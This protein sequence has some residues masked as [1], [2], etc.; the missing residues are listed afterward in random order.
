MTLRFL[1]PT[2]EVPANR[3]VREANKATS[4]KKFQ[5]VASLAEKFLS[6]YPDGFEDQQYYKDERGYK[7]E[8]AQV[9]KEKLGEETFRS[10]LAEGRFA[11]IARIALSLISKTNLV[12]PNESMALADA[13]KKQTTYHERFAQALFTLLYAPGKQGGHFDDF[14]GL[15]EEMK[16]CKWTTATYFPFLL[17]PEEEIF[18]KPKV[19]QEAA[20]AFTY[21]G[22]NYEPTPSWAGY[23]RMR[24]F[25]RYVKEELERQTTLVPRDL[26]DVQGFYWCVQQ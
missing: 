7:E 25:A 13:L 8:A 5:S 17:R 10:L 21:R 6:Q 3:A 23:I 12:F 14:C 2:D 16:A 22:L 9:L 11:D 15:L 4:F 26:M 19:T 24:N 1:E 18:V 20:D